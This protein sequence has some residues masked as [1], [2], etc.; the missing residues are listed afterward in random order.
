MRNPAFGNAACDINP[1]LDHC[2]VAHCEDEPVIASHILPLCEKHIIAGY[3]EI[4]QY[5]AT[6]RKMISLE[7]NRKPP[8]PE[9]KPRIPGVLGIPLIEDGHHVYYMQFG[10][11]VKIGV[12][13]NLPQ[14]LEDIPCDELLT[15][16]RG[17][18]ELEK[19]RHHEFR[20][21]R[22]NGEWFTKTPELAQHI[23]AVVDR[24]GD[25]GEGM[26]RFIG[27]LRLMHRGLLA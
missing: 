14:R 3:R 6:R 4:S 23:Q 11:R 16:E 2:V 20:H 15:V 13:S 25:L 24:E 17:G 22:V 26:R 21:C 9:S 18:Y 8:A 1:A 12:T 19:Q 7:P 5:L 27:R 10:D